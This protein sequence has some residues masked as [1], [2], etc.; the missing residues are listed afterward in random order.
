MPS[1]AYEIIFAE[2]GYNSAL[3]AGAKENFQSSEHNKNKYGQFNH[4]Y[5]KNRDVVDYK[6]QLDGEGNTVGKLFEVAAG[7]TL[8]LEPEDGILFMFLVITNLHASTAG[9]ANSLL[10]RWARMVPKGTRHEAVNVG[11]SLI[12]PRNGDGK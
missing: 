5:I 10:I 8:I 12:F 3:A 7:D 6:I 11:G 4:L 9:T 2:A 1:N